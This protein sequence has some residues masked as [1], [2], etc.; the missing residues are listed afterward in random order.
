MATSSVSICWPFSSKKNAFVCPVP[1]AIRNTRSDDCTTAS[2]TAGSDTNTSF[3][4]TG[5][6]TTRE[7]PTPRSTRF[8]SGNAA[9]PGMRSTESLPAGLPAMSAAWISP[10]QTAT[11]HAAATP[12]HAHFRLVRF[13]DDL[14]DSRMEPS[15]RRTRAMERRSEGYARSCRADRSLAAV[16]PFPFGQVCADFFGILWHEHGL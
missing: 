5:N 14:F 13:I 7:R 3:R 10:T 11:E 1:L 9:L 15:S 16:G 4:A 2:S 8:E 6:C 12:A